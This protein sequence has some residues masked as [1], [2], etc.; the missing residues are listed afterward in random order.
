MRNPFMPTLPPY[1][2]LSLFP[3]KE[4]LAG[5]RLLAKACG[6]SLI[7]TELS[8]SSGS[9]HRS[10]PSPD[11]YSSGSTAS[12]NPLP[13]PASSTALARTVQPSSH[14]QPALL[15]HLSYPAPAMTISSR[16]GRIQR[17]SWGILYDGITSSRLF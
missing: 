17:T 14:S 12:F 3:E 5:E 7:V 15:N 2:P 9:S 16:E 13:P 4:R 10:H 6:D 11:R 1:Y 8:S